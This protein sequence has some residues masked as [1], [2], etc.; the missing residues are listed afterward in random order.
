MKRS[1]REITKAAAVASNDG[2]HREREEE[3]EE[4]EDTNKVS[5]V[6]TPSGTV[7]VADPSSSADPNNA[8]AAEVKSKRASVNS[9]SSILSSSSAAVLPLLQTPHTIRL[10]KLIREGSVEYAETAVLR[11]EQTAA[12][13]SPV[14]LWDLLG[15]LT[16]ILFAP[17]WKTRQAAA[18]ALQV[19]ARHLPVA[20]QCDFLERASFHHDHNCINSNSSIVA[21]EVT[22]S[23][24][25]STIE[26][27]SKLDDS[28]VDALM[29]RQ[30]QQQQSKA[31]YLTVNELLQENGES[32]IDRV[33]AQ[34]RELLATAESRYDVGMGAGG[35]NRDG[36]YD[37]DD[38]ALRSLD[39]SCRT[40]VS[41]SSV[42]SDD[43][44]VVAESSS[45]VQARV[46][47][48]RRILAGRLGLAA[49]DDAIG[50][51]AIFA[52][53]AITSGDLLLQ[54]A[55]SISSSPKTT[56]QK[57]AERIQQAAAARKT[58]KTKDSETTTDHHETSA[59]DEAV[60]LESN[61]PH[62]VR[63]L[64][65]MEMQA[66]QQQLTASY[67]HS[68]PQALLATELIYRMLDPVWYVRHGAVL[69]ILALLRAWR[70]HHLLSPRLLDETTTTSSSRSGS[71]RRFGA[72]PQDILARCLCVLALD[73]FGD[74]S[75]GALDFSDDA[76]ANDVSSSTSVVAP[77]REVVGQT[78][79]VLLAMAPD[80]VV[81]DALAVLFRQCQFAS[82]W[83]VRHG[84]LVALK[85]VVVVETTG[86]MVANRA[87][88]ST[89]VSRDE[90]KSTIAFIARVAMEHLLDDSDDVKSVAAQ[91]LI[92]FGR[93]ESESKEEERKHLPEF[94]GDA[95]Q[96]LWCALQSV[97]SVS[98]CIVDLV[99]LFAMFVD[100]DCFSFLCRI[101][102][103]S[104]E[105]FDGLDLADINNVIRMLLR[106]LDSDFLSVR[107]SALRSIG[108]L[109]RD[110]AFVSRSH[111]HSKY[112]SLSETMQLLVERVFDLFFMPSEDSASDA[113]EHTE[114]YPHAILEETWKRLSD[115]CIDLLKTEDRDC[116]DYKVL[117]RYFEIGHERSTETNDAPVQVEAAV[118]IAYFL[119]RSTSFESISDLAQASLLSYLH[120]PWTSQCEASCLLYRALVNRLAN[121][122]SLQSF[123][124]SLNQDV[125]LLCLDERILIADSSSLGVA[126]DRTFLSA[127]AD[128][129]SGSKCPPEAA[130]AVVRVWTEE[131]Q[132]N[133]GPVSLESRR[134][135]PVS[136]MR[137]R[138][139]L[140]GAVLT[141]GLPSKLTPIVRALMTSFTN[142][143]A[144]VS[145]KTQTCAYLTQLLQLIGGEAEFERAHTKILNTL[146]DAVIFHSNNTEIGSARKACAASSVL[147]SL[148]QT[149]PGGR[150]L[151]DIGPLWSRLLPLSKAI[152][153]I[154]EH[155]VLLDS[156]S[157]LEVLCGG[158]SPDQVLTSSLIDDCVPTL[159]DLACADGPGD[160][161]NSAVS[162]VVAL[163]TVYPGHLLQVAIPI[164]TDN[165]EDR[166]HDCRRL[167]ACLLLGRLMEAAGTEIC[168]F[169]RCL[170]PLVLSLVTDHMVECAQSANGIFALLVRVA[171]LVRQRSSVRM[172]TLD[173]HGES[174]IDHL[175]FGKP[176]PT[177]DFPIEL[178]NA[179]NTRQIVLR[180]YQKEGIA[181]L[182]FL[183]TVNLSG[184]L[185]DG[186]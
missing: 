168:P 146:C 32:S 17:T 58:K 176:L 56:R 72:W 177:C 158:L 47:L 186:K 11:L 65:V 170:L 154:T 169:V 79:S 114:T 141:K 180:N 115:T 143:S 55:P 70:D 124:D 105:S 157:L 84:A 30:Q 117:S 119:C 6:L 140:A 69:G 2:S 63:A 94:L 48:Q 40:T 133:G 26:T 4:E 139:M 126:C 50:G 167:S 159:I 62:T 174:V 108:V 155:S 147:R 51:D 145:R 106:L 109:S 179:L 28:D 136:S 137:I 120:S 53:D 89:L 36:K 144:S 152:P 13:L 122:S 121:R 113:D 80:S 76:V 45:F 29:S 42:A 142:E 149:V 83:E 49:I 37:N 178:R 61:N 14:Q 132:S 68:N 23:K 33:L 7:I 181:W 128:V 22:N 123:E 153:S 35:D 96:P 110:S 75:G 185:C 129:V 135:S 160:F 59:A 43:S 165:L 107:V 112:Q 156:I 66:Q 131:V 138:A 46:Q 162:S 71:A 151:A 172:E 54:S 74:Y 5:A 92:E 87:T 64:L 103:I 164:L 77:V 34:G 9:S 16:D 184:A 86:I 127:M 95:V 111:K 31:L 102:A 100:H 150:T 163:C 57:H 93:G 98:S 78:V 1:R 161:R 39:R 182:Q 19:V 67:S 24:Y 41:S 82:E 175:I 3:E 27:S 20:D 81:S 44:I 166:S 10:L 60:E 38:N 91:I 118:A 97:R 171:P 15:R 12:A 25:H 148:V 173:E 73:R 8:A 134:M 18:S 116:L 99:A 90:T 130:D 183:R 21:S 125:P 104:S 101:N 52:A 88:K 85:Y